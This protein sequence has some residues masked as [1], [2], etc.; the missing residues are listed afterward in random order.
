MTKKNPVFD[1]N[2]T[3]MTAHLFAAHDAENCADIHGPPKM[4]RP[5]L[6]IKGCSITSD[7]VLHTLEYGMFSYS[8][9]H[10]S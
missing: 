3:E 10:L 6:L 1:I 5:I 2:S 9:F 7:E 4:F 8:F